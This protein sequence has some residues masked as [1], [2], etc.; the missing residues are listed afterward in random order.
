LLKATGSCGHAKV[1]VMTNVG[2]VECKL[3]QINLQQFK[4]DMNGRM[5]SD[6]QRQIWTRRPL[7]DSDLAYAGLN[8]LMAYAIWDAETT[9]QPGYASHYRLASTVWLSLHEGSRN[10]VYNKPRATSASVPTGLYSCIE[11]CGHLK[12]FFTIRCLQN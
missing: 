8:A 9:G 7:N 10:S 5:Q 2:N 3:G 6:T 12:H 4:A 1:H 11:Q